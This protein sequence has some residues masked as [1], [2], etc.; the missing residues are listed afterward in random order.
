MRR[1]FPDSQD[2]CGDLVV[3][4][5]A[6][7]SMNLVT[8]PGFR[9]GEEKGREARNAPAISPIDGFGGRVA[10]KMIG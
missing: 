6:R 9:E 4:A 7:A 10:E 5:A 1:A 8:K 2:S 3:K